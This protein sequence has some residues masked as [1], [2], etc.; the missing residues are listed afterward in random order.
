MDGGDVR[1]ADNDGVSIAYQV[2]GQ[3]PRDLVFV[4]GTMS[5]LELWWGDPLA[6]AMLEAL[7]RFSRV[8]LFDKPGTGLSDP[9]PA[10]PTVEQRASDVVAVMDAAGSRR[11]VI[12]G[13][14]EG[15]IPAIT[16]AATQPERV[17]AL[18]LLSAMATSEWHAELGFGPELHQHFWG[19]LDEATAHWGQGI[20]MSAFAPTWTTNP[21]LR[22]LLPS[23]ERACM[24]PAM[25]RSVLQGLHDIDLRAAAAAIS[26]PTLIAHPPETLISDEFGRDLHR[27]I[28]HSS[29]VAL[30]GPDHLP[31][32]HNSEL[33]PAAVENF[34][35]GAESAPSDEHRI[36]TTV[37]F[38]DIA[39]ST[40]RLAEVGDDRWRAIL[41]EHDKRLGAL[42]TR[43]GGE[44]VKHTGDGTMTRFARPGRAVR[45][46]VAMRDE[47]RELGLQLRVGV[48]TGE[49]DVVDGDIFGMT[50]NIAARVAAAADI[51]AV[52]A[53]ST[54]RDLV[55]GSP[56]SFTTRGV[57]DL[58]GVPGRWELLA[59][60][61]ETRGTAPPTSY[62]TDVRH[63][64][65]EGAETRS[66]R[67]MDRAL[68]TSARV[69]P[70]TMRRL[71]SRLAQPRE[72]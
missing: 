12:V 66:L 54:V 43:Y 50:V 69:A 2:F 23:V 33:F 11:A 67:P 34:L 40:R 36:M 21:V 72:Q 32:V 18:V 25:A 60:E 27:R 71:M 70:R 30:Q 20:L 14:S 45:F 6:T 29:Y 13:F 56:L 46:A 38:T 48:H 10:A 55:I 19:I 26:V 22:R 53:T 47:A 64:A 17:E 9:V 42:L 51:D 39:D 31:W 7:G 3:G 8:I 24:S 59:C 62:E 61:G 63:V 4:C 52:F 35:T 68:V 28:P 65:S 49:C 44:H 1:Y 41:A 16:L 5:H 15:G 37:V 57:R 58:K